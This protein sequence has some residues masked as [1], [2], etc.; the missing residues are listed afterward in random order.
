MSVFRTLNEML[1][2]INS[3]I[4]GSLTYPNAQMFEL[5]ELQTKDER[6]FPV[7][8]TGNQNGYKISLNDSY[9]LQCYHRLID[10]ETETDP[11]GGK[12]A[13]PFQMRIMTIRNV[14]LGN[15]K[16]LPAKT[17]ETN[18]EIKNNVYRY[19]PKILSSKELV[20]TI[21]DNVNK[22]EILA[23]EFEGTDLNF[24]SLDVIAFYIDYQIR[25]FIRC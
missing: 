11:S 6:T 10:S 24:L 12:G 5:A 21:N 22:R 23:E 18:E 7:I 3:D 13:S 16:K 19:I 2:E 25:Q 9:A 15:T 1:K 8:N 14:W 4:S 20:R 17:Y